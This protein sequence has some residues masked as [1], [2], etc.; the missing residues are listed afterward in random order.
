MSY[1]E[2]FQQSFFEGALRRE[3]PDGFLRATRGDKFLFDPEVAEYLQQIYRLLLDL[4]VCETRL[5]SERGEE[6]EKARPCTHKFPMS[7]LP[8]I[9]TGKRTSLN[10]REVPILLQK[11]GM[12]GHGGWS[13]S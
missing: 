10:V 5:A 9:A 6:R 4:E 2:S 12:T 11:S 13:S 7:A 8:P 1:P 3:D